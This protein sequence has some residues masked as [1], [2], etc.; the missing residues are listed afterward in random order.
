MKTLQ[1]AITLAAFA[2]LS[3]G[4]AQAADAMSK[5]KA[6]GAME[7]CYGVALAGK[8]DCKAGA[9]TSCAGTSK[10]DYQGDAWKQV[11][12]GTCVTIKTPKGMGSLAPKA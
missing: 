11:P 7:K 6:A 2:A 9:G 8:N 12:A 4:V 5:D 3:A 10:V 1:T